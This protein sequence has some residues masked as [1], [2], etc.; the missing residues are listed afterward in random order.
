MQRQQ[1]S[2][3]VL[4]PLDSCFWLSALRVCAGAHG[5][6]LTVSQFTAYVQT[7]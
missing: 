7:V 1:W 6:D 4:Q 2:P 3:E 5:V